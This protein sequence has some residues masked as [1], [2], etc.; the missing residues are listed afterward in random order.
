MN[1]INELFQQLVSQISILE[2]VVKGMIIGIVASAPMGPVGVLCIQRTL[3]KGR[4][5]GFV[6]GT[7]AALS[8]ILYALL[9]GY[10]LS[11]IYDIISNQSTLFWLQIIGA[12]IMFIFG[13]HTF[14]TNPMKNTRNVSRNKSSLLQNGITGFFITLSNPTIILLFLGLFTP[15]NFMLPEQPFFM[16][17]IGYLSIFGGAMLWWFFITYVVSKLR[18]RFDV[19]GIRVINRI[20]G[21]AVMLGA[22][23]G[24]VLIS[25][26]VWSLH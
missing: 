25:T 8:D 4:A 7:G 11:F 5:Y 1:E 10:G 19:R 24:I 17:C 18:V 26:G 22:L 3:N 12:S 16:Q 9:T 14:R 15:L 20:I 13:L 21:V 2:I 23:I 6:T